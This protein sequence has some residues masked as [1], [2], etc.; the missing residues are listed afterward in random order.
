MAKKIGVNG[1]QIE[2]I[3]KILENGHG[4]HRQIEYC[5]EAGALYLSFVQ[6]R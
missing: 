4:G 2:Q 5:A 6:R 3:E 1:T